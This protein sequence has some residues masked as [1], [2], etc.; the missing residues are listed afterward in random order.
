MGVTS[1]N[2]VQ[3][4]AKARWGRSIALLSLLLAGLVAFHN[5]FS[6]PFVFDDDASILAN[7]TIRHLWPPWSMLSPPVTGAP[8]TNRPVAN[9]TFAINYAIGGMHVQGYHA[10]NLTA[11]LLTGLLMFG[12][13]R[14]TFESPTL[15]GYF[16]SQQIFV[17][18]LCTLLWLVHPLMTE[19][20]TY[21][22]GRTEVLMALFYLATLYASIRYMEPGSSQFWMFLAVTACAVGMGAKEVMVSAPLM[23]LFYDRTFISGTF[24]AAWNSRRGF[25]VLLIATWTLLA[26]L[27]TAGGM[28]AGTTGFAGGVTW[29]AY[30][31][32]QFVAI[33][34][35]IKLTFWPS[36]L[37]L[38][39]GTYLVTNPLQYV[40]CGLLVAALAAAS[41]WAV[42]RRPALGFLGV[43]FF[44]ILAPS[45]SVIPVI[46]QTVAER[47]AYLAVPV[48]IILAVL[49][50]YR[51]LRP[52]YLA[53]GI[54]AAAALTAATIARNAV[55]HTA[56]S[57][58]SD[59]V[60]KWPTESRAHLALGFALMDQPDSVLAALE[61]FKEVIRIDP[62]HDMAY[63]CMGSCLSL[64]P[65]RE[66][67][68]EIAFRKEL[69]LQPLSALGRLNY[70]IH[71]SKVPGRERDAERQLRI[72]LN[73]QT[74]DASIKAQAHAAIG[75]LLA[76][77]P[78]RTKEGIAE[79]RRA[80]KLYPDL[81]TPHDSL[82]M[83]ISKGGNNLPEAISELRIAHDLKPD[84]VEI[85]ND[86]ASVL[87]LTKD[88]KL[89]AVAIYQ[90][91]IRLKPDSWEVH[92]N[93]GNLFLTL[94]GRTAEAINEF[95][96]VIRLQPSNAKAHEKLGLALAGSPG[97]LENAVEQFDAAARLD[98]DSEDA[99]VNLASALA[100]I[101]GRQGE[102]IEQYKAAIRLRPND[103]D[104]HFRLGCILAGMASRG[105]EA[106][107]EFEDALETKPDWV[108]AHYNI[109]A[110]LE[111]EPSRIGEAVSHLK[112]ALRLAPDDTASRDLLRKLTAR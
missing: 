68:A 84:S 11:H 18:W 40:P 79:L 16:G 10:L 13:L 60:N 48:V 47:R 26:V 32:T 22:S 63:C 17:A 100:Q 92:F 78:G 54:A 12:I 62:K 109:A 98:P 38:D 93:L 41:I 49:S 85:S 45:S 30:L 27:M 31:L 66:A 29:W 64:I 19:P 105:D 83:A 8:V 73:M 111:K 57:I 71:L 55:Y 23:V 4:I 110:I 3:F 42:A 81:P 106:V 1:Q 37:I 70:G 33:A 46:T 15:K 7:P 21:V 65:G 75:S 20:V 87:A 39:Y 77:L 74:D 88:S 112:E 58:W 89:E 56:V 103:G 59:T 25:Y 72:S 95:R 94:E 90:D 36:P 44:A 14:R 104:A 5:S 53:I 50:L 2:P 76:K 97:Q 101:P 51:F 69:E 107:V 61:Q 86:L 80:V 35:Y 67:E 24:R 43:W 99:H 9:V 34:R 102:A 28:R 82:A 108:D 6:G 96:E 52:W 91:S